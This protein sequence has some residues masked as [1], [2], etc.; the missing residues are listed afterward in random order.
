M[1]TKLIHRQEVYKGKIFSVAEDTIEFEDGHR[2][3][4][5]MVI[6]N[7]AAAVV[8]LTEKNEVVL[9]RQYRNATDGVVLEIPAGKLEEGEDPLECARRE[10]EEEIGYKAECVKK[11]CAMYSAIGFSNEKLHVYQANGLVK[12]Q[13][14]LDQDEF[15]EVCTYPIEQV[16]DMIHRGEIQDGKTIVGVLSV[17]CEQLKKK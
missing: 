16:V 11:I 3:K 15:I 6:H 5:D 9:V 14:K 7:G 1:K 4:W 10:L 13:Q 2:A 8:P 17:F 12:S